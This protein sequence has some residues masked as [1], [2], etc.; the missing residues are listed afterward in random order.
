MLEFLTLKLEAFG[1][2]ISDSSLKIAKLKKKDKFLSLAS[3]GEIEIEPGI[4]KGG[5]IQDEDSLAKIIKEALVK[6]KGEKLNTNYVIAS[7]P[8]EK[9]FLEVIQ[10][11]KL[12]PEEL[13]DAV[14]F[15]AENYIPLSIEDVYLDFQIIQPLYDHLDHSDVLIAA[16][17]KKI[18]DPYVS[19]FKKAG[20][21]PQ[22][23][24]VESIAIAR[25]LIKNGISPYPVLLI[26]FGAN[27]TGLMIFSGYSL[28]FT[29][30]IPA[31]S[32]EVTKVISQE[33]NISFQEAEKLKMKFGLEKE[34]RLK[35]KNGIKTEVTPGK[36]LKIVTPLLT[37]LVEEIKK[38]LDYYQTHIHHEHLP[39]D[40]KEIHKVLLCGGGANFKGL[41]EFLSLA[42]KTPVEL[43]N[44]WAN[45]LKTPL[46]EIPELPYEKSLAFTTALGLALRGIKG[47]C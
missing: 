23:L 16:L 14:Y 21:Q 25:S 32:Q 39:P 10:M 24:E 33:L 31:S 15:E 8:E 35:I 5:E 4:I 38:S 46:R 22:A 20:L 19:C 26:D 13:K 30:A 17:P 18:I 28:R 3:Y 37:N 11:P 42:L 2:D 27:R 12:K 41:P 29:R 43:G 36:I 44:P 47:G 9:A 34:Y 1:L 6:V 7:L 40:G 45:I